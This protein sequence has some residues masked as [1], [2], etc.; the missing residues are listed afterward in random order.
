VTTPHAQSQYQVRFDWGLAG[1]AAVSHDADVIVWVDQLGSARSATGESHLPEYGVIA[2]SIQNRRALADW[3]LQRQG[4][5]G[6]RFT[7]AVIAA[8]QA[9]PDGSLRFAVEDLLGAGAVIDALAD[10]GIDYCSPESA[11]AAAA[12]TG[13]RNAT[14]HLISSSASGQ[15]LGRPAVSLDAVD[16]VTVLREFRVSDE[17]FR[18]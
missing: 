3:A 7:I 9:R 8:G 1:A 10:V 2:G 17:R 13:L 12:F 5:L 15:E 4:D 16:D 6:D 14:S 11:A 18:P